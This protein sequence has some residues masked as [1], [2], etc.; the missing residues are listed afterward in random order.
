M[1][2]HGTEA[3]AR[4]IRT[5]TNRRPGA[6]HLIVL[7]WYDKAGVER[8]WGLTHIS[9]NFWRRISA[10]ESLVMHQVKIWY[11]ED[12]S[13][14]RPVIIDDS[15]ERKFQESFGIVS[16]AIVLVVGFGLAIATRRRVRAW[17]QGREAEHN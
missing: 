1:R 2:D 13:W 6:S 10:G 8:H 11:L 12:N 7:A 17:S 5:S 15:D 14:A 4:I 16:G 3:M 9:E